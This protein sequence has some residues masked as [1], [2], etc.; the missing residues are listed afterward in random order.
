MLEFVNQHHLESTSLVSQMLFKEGNK[1][2]P[3]AQFCSVYACYK[4]I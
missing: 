4:H 3:P 2:A 1:V